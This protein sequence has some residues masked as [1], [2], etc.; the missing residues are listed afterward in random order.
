MNKLITAVAVS[1]FIFMAVE[2]KALESRKV[3][4]TDYIGIAWNNELVHYKLEFKK[5]ELSGGAYAKV[6][7]NGKEI[8]SQI[9]DVERFEDD[10]SIKS[11]NVWFQADILANQSVSYEIQPGVKGISDS[12]GV[13]IVFD[14]D[15][16][17][18]KTKIASGEEVGTKLLL[19]NKEFTWPVDADKVS[20]PLLGILLTSEKITGKGI[21]NAPFK[22]KSVKSELLSSGPL[23]AE[24]KTHYVFSEGY[25]TFRA[26][27]IKNCPMII[28]DEEFDNGISDKP[29][30]KFDCFHSFTLN[31]GDF[32][33]TETYLSAKTN[34][35][36]KVDHA[37]LYDIMTNEADESWLKKG[38]IG[39][40]YFASPVSGFSLKFTKDQTFFYLTGYPKGGHLIRFV[41]PG[42]DAVGFASLDTMKWKNP[43][44]IR[45][46]ETSNGRLM[47][48]FPL[49]R[50]VQDWISD[51]L[52]VGPNYT[53][54]TL[55]VPPSICRRNYG[56]M[57]SKAENEK[58]E[59]LKSLISLT[60]KLN[61]QPLDIVKDW[62]LD[63]PEPKAS[64]TWA[65]KTGP[66][67][68]KALDRMRDWIEFNQVFGNF[69]STSMSRHYTFAKRWYP[70]LA[71]IIDNEKELTSE[72]RKELRRKCAFLAYIMNSNDTFPWGSGHHLNNPNMSIMAME[73]RLKSS[74]LVK[75]H[76]MFKP[77]GAW[78]VDF[79]KDYTARYTKVSGA[80]Y[81]NP[82]YTLGV[83]FAI[84]SELNNIIIENQLGDIL[85]TPLTK[86]SIDFI[87]NWLTPPDP[88]FNGHRV[89]LPVGNTSYQSVPLAFGKEIVG[90]YKDRDPLT[91]GKM[92]WMT[93]QTLPDD[94]KIK[95]V[96][97]DIAPE[98]KSG[99]FE[100]YGVF[101][102]HG[103]G[104]PYETLF[105]LMAGAC[106]GHDEWESDQMAYTIYAK[107][108]PINLHFGN[109]YFP[110]FCRPWLRNRISIDHKFEK[111][112][113]NPT[114]VSAVSFTPRADY[115]RAFREID[116]IRPLN[117]EYPQLEKVYKFNDEER[118]NWI[119][120]PEWEKIPM[121]V[122][123]RQVMFLKDPD[124]KDPNYF[125]FR[126]TFDGRP[127]RPT[128]LSFWFLANSSSEISNYHHFDG[129]CNVDM[130]VFV[131]TPENAILETG[132]YGHTA[133][134][135]GL[136]T[137]HDMKYFPEGKRREDQLLF[138]LKQPA[139]KGYMVVLY[140]RLKKD[141]P[142]A[143]FTRLADNAVKI[144]TALSKDY[145]LMDSDQFEFKNEKLSF[146]GLSAAIRFYQDKTV[147]IN[148]EGISEFEVADKHISGKGSFEAVIEN[149]TVKTGIFNGKSTVE[150][151]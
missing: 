95:I 113:R 74:L 99:F 66:N 15:S 103:F 87:P 43:E 14:K 142:P 121:T 118:K 41:Q 106:D 136:L 42:S 6:E 49:Q 47:V 105:H 56:I 147:I 35:N 61:S 69:G 97:K 151:K 134:P 83:T 132:K 10:G 139:G 130:D 135:Y 44:G 138:R 137:G 150:V 17:T 127:T 30:D 144:E 23:F 126:E 80:P 116:M 40:S 71:K 128:D 7:S 32:K 149:G 13:K 114:D 59:K 51:S 115:V 146:K 91:A 101:F 62:I 45:F 77:W 109:G 111:S 125:V 9:T 5:G 48:N 58:Q 73:A 96:E 31:E 16:V 72:D 63:W 81:E 79:L 2:I 75:D 24:V 64:A 148:N 82:H 21:I 60:T 108:Q 46:G 28:I 38:G 124:P 102:R 67:G 143:V 117:S 122:W 18:L 112:E 88:R 119:E 52:S 100:K 98:L 4:I 37:E 78:S 131:N 94:K 84:Y 104:T 19:I 53:G 129:Q 89:I 54:K 93:N 90:Y 26:K 50:Y 123:Y 76:P 1:C 55:F 3:S 141:D 29:W 68:Q 33:P 22:I 20:G 133:E 11:Y 110:M 140:P 25:W 120:N 27:M 107:G 36:G 70:D 39:N 92:Q 34:F 86:K 145:V 85:D 57:I 65:Q 8:P 12:S